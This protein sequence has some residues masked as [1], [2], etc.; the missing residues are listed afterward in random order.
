M[1]SSVFLAPLALGLFL[2]APAG[3]AITPSV[4]TEATPVS[5]KDANVVE[6]GKISPIISALE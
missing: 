3:A 2:A 4:V 1:R 5:P 6:L